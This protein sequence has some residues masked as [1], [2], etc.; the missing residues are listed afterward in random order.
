MIKFLQL[1]ETN[2]FYLNDYDIENYI[3]LNF[4]ENKKISL[5]DFSFKNYNRIE[6]KIYD[7]ELNEDI[8]YLIQKY[9][10]S[11]ISL[12]K[13]K[14]INLIKRLFMIKF[15]NLKKNK[16][17]FNVNLDYLIRG[18]LKNIAKIEGSFVKENNKKYRKEVFF[19][20]RIDENKSINVYAEYFHSCKNIVKIKIT[21]KEYEN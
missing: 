3:K 14:K 2:E 21:E 4:D 17:I 16:D 10:S 1:H 12:F 19:L 18:A 9:N 15:L 6:V 20:N 8:F 7:M 13:I 5:N 11:N